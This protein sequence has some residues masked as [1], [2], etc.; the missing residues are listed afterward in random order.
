MSEGHASLN[1]IG[2][3][4]D[5]S[6]NIMIY[7][8]K[9][10]VLSWNVPKYHH[11]SWNWKTFHDIWWHEPD[12]NFDDIWW[13]FIKCHEMFFNVTW[14][15]LMTCHDM[16]W[17]GQSDSESCVEGVV[18]SEKSEILEGACVR[19]I[20]GS[21]TL[22]SICVRSLSVAGY[23]F[24]QSDIPQPGFRD[25]AIVILSSPISCCCRNCCIKWI[26]FS[27]CS[28]LMEKK[29]WGAAFGSVQCVQTSRHTDQPP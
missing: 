24:S 20:W 8:D 4:Y 22:I 7:H 19:D 26:S 12:E 9:R 27:N 2:S 23:C 11:V 28:F 3:F 13:F 10:H 15:H 5:L 17:C 14:W 1:K 29:M 16:S 6:W 18:G 25:V 21:E